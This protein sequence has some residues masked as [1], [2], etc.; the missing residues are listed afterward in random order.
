MNCVKDDLAVIAIDPADMKLSGMFVTC[1]Y[2][3]PPRR[4][5]LPDGFAHRASNHGSPR[6][7]V[8]FQREIT[9]Y[10]DAGRT[11]KTMFAVIP[12][13]A[14]RPIRPQPDDARDETLAWKDVPSR[15]GVEA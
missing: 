14:L 9:A 2:I 3:A 10:I 4:F 12:D 7:V 1:L 8:E 11:R 13:F 5:T 15:E 6:W